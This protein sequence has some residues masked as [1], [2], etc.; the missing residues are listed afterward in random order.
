MYCISTIHLNFL[1]SD[2]FQFQVQFSSYHHHIKYMQYSLHQL[3]VQI[4][5][6]SLITNKIHFLYIRQLKQISHPSHPAQ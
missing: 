4:S 6:K 5:T 3:L 1:F 2:V